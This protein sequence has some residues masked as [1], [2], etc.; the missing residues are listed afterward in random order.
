MHHGGDWAPIFANALQS[1]VQCIRIRHVNGQV[2]GL[3]PSSLKS[4]QRGANFAQGQHIGQLQVDVSRCGLNPLGLRTLQQRTLEARVIGN[5]KQVLRL[6]GQR[7]APQQNNAWLFGLCQ[8]DEC[9]RRHATAT[10]RSHHHGALVDVVSR[11]R[12]RRCGHRCQR[13]AAAIGVYPDFQ[14]AATLQQLGQNGLGHFA[15]GACAAFQ[16]NGF[17]GCRWPLQRGGAR[18]GTYA[19][20]I[21]PR[22]INPGQAKVA[23]SV[24]HGDKRAAIGC[25]LCSHRTAGVKGFAV[26]GNRLVHRCHRAQTTQENDGIGVHRHAADH[27]GGNTVLGQTGHQRNSHASSFVGHHQMLRT[28]HA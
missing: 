26:D 6:V 14:C 13:A 9:C 17:D 8:R 20:Q 28:Q 3:R 24:L 21:G 7:G 25:Q 5:G 2:T 22:G 27:A 10:A 4:R 12:G 18:Q 15:G 16:V 1:G 23:A 19:A 11:Q